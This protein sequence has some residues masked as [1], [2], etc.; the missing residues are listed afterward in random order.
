MLVDRSQNDE[1]KTTVNVYSLRAKERPTVSAP[2]TWAEMSRALAR[3]D[4]SKLMFEAPALL[5][6]VEKVGD[7][8]APLLTL[9]Q[10]LPSHVDA[11]RGSLS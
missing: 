9:K 4:P 2:V 5:R 10:K 1:H 11:F 7:L 6:R 8:F 3:K